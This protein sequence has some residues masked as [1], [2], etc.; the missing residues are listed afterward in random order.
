V[1]KKMERPQKRQ[2]VS[3]VALQTPLT[4][5]QILAFDVDYYE[6]ESTRIKQFLESFVKRPVVLSTILSAK[7]ERTC[8][9]LL[10]WVNIFHD[11]MQIPK[12]RLDGALKVRVCFAEKAIIM[13]LDLAKEMDSILKMVEQDESAVSDDVLRELKKLVEA[14]DTGKR[15]A[16][17]SFF[18]NYLST[19]TDVVPFSLRSSTTPMT[20]ENIET[21]QE[22]LDNVR[23]FLARPNMVT[24]SEDEVV[25][26]VQRE[27]YIDTVRFPAT[28]E[29]LI[30]KFNR[31]QNTFEIRPTQY[32]YGLFTLKDLKAGQKI[33][34]YYG[35]SVAKELAEQLPEGYDKL[36]PSANRDETIVG[37]LMSEDMRKFNYLAFV[38]DPGYGGSSVSGWIGPYE[39]SNVIN[40]TENGQVIFVTKNPVKANDELL[41]FY[42]HEYWQDTPEY[43]PNEKERNDAK[44]QLQRKSK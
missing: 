44:R 8:R 3:R 40:K 21:I 16:G 39:R 38:N 4:L 34:T 5:D 18:M 30:A 42:G 7:V 27:G 19:L 6:T 2:N 41:F 15:N 17:L 33:G 12:N 22:L 11:N 24:L 36:M 10:A 29:E 26:L 20:T 32:G 1:E 9:N 13:M 31:S 23:H 28:K 25:D 14:V 43:Y 37:D 35:P